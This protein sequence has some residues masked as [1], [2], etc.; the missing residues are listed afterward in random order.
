M[1]EALIALKNL[2]AATSDPT[3]RQHIEQAIKV[4]SAELKGNKHLAN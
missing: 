3:A 1:D 4:R 2:L